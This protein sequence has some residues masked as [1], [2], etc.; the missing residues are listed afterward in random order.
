[1]SRKIRKTFPKD[2]HD[3][4]KETVNKLKSQIRK[5]QKENRDLKSEN[6]TLLTAWGK[7]ECFIDEL[8]ENIPV[9]ELIKNNKNKLSENEEKE[10]VR[11]KWAQ[12]RKENL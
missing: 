6:N 8:T 2:E 1:M 11:E 4:L 5:L 12:W 9:E 3:S 7:T 10:I